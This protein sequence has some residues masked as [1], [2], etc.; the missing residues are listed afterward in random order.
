MTWYN[1]IYI[2]SRHNNVSSV[3]N[4]YLHKKGIFLQGMFLEQKNLHKAGFRT[5]PEVS[6][7]ASSTL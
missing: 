1:N 7:L 3:I 6:L 5:G 4:I 2:I